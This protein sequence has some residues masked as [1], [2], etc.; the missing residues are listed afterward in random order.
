MVSGMSVCIDACKEQYLQ[1]VE[2]HVEY[3][4]LNRVL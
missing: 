3:Y 1:D 2:N 4:R